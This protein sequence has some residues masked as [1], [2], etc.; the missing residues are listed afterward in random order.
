ML[1]KLCSSVTFQA[2]PRTLEKNPTCWGL[3]GAGQPCPSSVHQPRLCAL[4][5]GAR[6][7]L[8]GTYVNGKGPGEGWV[9]LKGEEQQG[10]RANLLAGLLLGSW[11]TKPGPQT[12]RQSSGHHFSADDDRIFLPADRRASSK[13]ISE[14]KDDTC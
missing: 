8:R 14:A 7:G 11:S 9:L 4:L 10:G 12:E 2:S 1:C 3:R 6:G 5:A 13:G